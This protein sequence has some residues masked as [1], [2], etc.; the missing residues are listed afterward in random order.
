[1]GEKV[2][3]YNSPFRMGIYLQRAARKGC[4]ISV[5]PEHPPGFLPQ[6]LP[7]QREAASG[8]GQQD[9]EGHTLEQGRAPR[10]I[11]CLG[12]E[13]EEQLDKGPRVWASSDW[14]P[15]S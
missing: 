8:L 2:R 12:E 3:F 5:G 9:G 10:G 1:M 15:L 4:R 6:P 11:S 7:C 13:E 14:N